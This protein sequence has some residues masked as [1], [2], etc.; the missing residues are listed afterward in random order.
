MEELAEIDEEEFP[1]TFAHPED[2]MRSRPSA[3]TPVNYDEHMNESRT[4]MDQFEEGSEGSS[5]DDQD[6]P[7]KSKIDMY[8][9]KKKFGG[10]NLTLSTHGEGD[11][12]VNQEDD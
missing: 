5:R 12:K 1:N 9:E 6:I 4:L 7:R 11:K 2:E 10:Q 8:L 3:P